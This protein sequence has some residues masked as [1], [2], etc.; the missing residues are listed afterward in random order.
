MKQ[1]CCGDLGFRDELSVLSKF[2]IC[3]LTSLPLLF[4]QSVQHL[5]KHLQRTFWLWHHNFWILTCKLPSKIV[6]KRTF[7]L[8]LETIMASI[9]AHSFLN[10]KACKWLTFSFRALLQ[11]A[12]ATNPTS[13]CDATTWFWVYW[14]WNLQWG[15]SSFKFLS[16]YK[17]PHQ[18]FQHYLKFWGDKRQKL[19]IRLKDIQIGLQ[20]V[21]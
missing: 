18:S 8:I 10:S 16:L 17:F 11:V 20:S 2:S 15:T 12:A 13:I 6:L 7:S 3:L 4:N 19:S 9:I 14:H 1:I 5:L 21:H